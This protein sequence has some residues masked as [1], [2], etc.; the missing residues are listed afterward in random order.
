[1]KNT[2]KCKKCG[3]EIEIS[4]ALRFQIEEQTKQDIEKKLKEKYEEKFSFEM[5]DLKKQLQEKN[6]KVETYKDQELKLR[7]EKRKL[8][9]EKK[10]I[11]LTVQRKI[12]EERKKTEE[13]ILKQ[14]AEEH[15]LKDKEKDKII[16]GLKESLDEARR[17]ANVGSQQ[18]QGE[19]LELDLE[20]ELKKSFPQDEIIA[21]EKGEKGADVRQIVKSPRGIVC[22]VI[23]WETKRAKAWKEAW[24]TKLKDDLRSRKANIPVIVTNI[25]PKEINNGILGQKNGVLVVG[26]NLY[27]PLA[28]ILRKNLLDVGYQKA[29]SIHRGEK[30]D[31]LYEYITSHEFIQQIEAIVEVYKDI[32]K[33]VGSERIVF[34]KSWKARDEQAKRLLLSA[35]HIIGSIQGKVGQTALPIKELDLLQLESGDSNQ[36]KE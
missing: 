35:A 28:V 27:L 10:E 26:F 25:F 32:V 15:Y 19:V 21:V 8:E 29:I 34:E 3:A 20:E 18:L 5:T 24:V 4:E 2:I 1:M 9:D 23:L 11:D 12:D 7:E 36:K 16:N 17:K 6:E 30:T 13:K 22:G 33:Q 31:L 14:A